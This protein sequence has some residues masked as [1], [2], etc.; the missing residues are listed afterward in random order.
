MFKE[1]SKWSQKLEEGLDAAHNFH[2]EFGARLPKNPKKIVFLGMGGSG[3]AGRLIKTFLDKRCSIP[4]FIIDTP[5][6]PAF[7]DTDTLAFV[8]SYSGNTWETVAGLEQLAQNFIPTV[9]VAHGGKALQIAEVK[10]L[11]QF[12]LLESGAPRTALGHFLGFYLGLFDLM[13]LLPGKKMIEQFRKELELYQQKYEQKKT[14]QDFL[15]RARDHSFFHLWGVAGDTAAAVYR[16]QTQFNENSKVHAVSSVFPE[17]NHN[18]LVGFTDQEEKPLV[19]LCSTAFLSQKLIH[20]VDALTQSLKQEGITLYKPP[21]FGDTWESQI[22]HLIVW[23]DYASVH[24]GEQRGVNLLEVRLI[25]SL[26]EKV[27]SKG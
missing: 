2:Y 15:D 22:F 20:S 25:D 4:S 11:I 13:G 18:L 7:V 9:V 10:N 23:A 26:K 3:I 8:A 12:I 1:L 19:M 6:I 27:R 5:E 14:F 24:L 17:L 16:A 21:I